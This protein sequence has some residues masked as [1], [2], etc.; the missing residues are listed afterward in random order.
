LLRSVN[1]STAPANVRRRRAA[2]LS[3]PR[4]RAGHRDLAQL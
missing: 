2:H 3:D 4:R 1:F